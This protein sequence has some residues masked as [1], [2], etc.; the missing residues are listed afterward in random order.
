MTGVIAKR[1]RPDGPDVD[2]GIV[3]LDALAFL[4]KREGILLTGKEEITA[5]YIAEIINFYNA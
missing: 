1:L 5:E 3:A 4:A 2:L